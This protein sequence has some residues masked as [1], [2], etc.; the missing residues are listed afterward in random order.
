MDSYQ[1]TGLIDNLFDCLNYQLTQAKVINNDV[2]Y[3]DG[4]IIRADSYKYGFVWRKSV[5]KF[6]GKL[7]FVN[8]SHFY[9]N[10]GFFVTL[11]FFPILIYLK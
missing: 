6:L 11:P 2:A 4:T 3:I 8:W 10:W 9:Y 5:I 7:K 1:Q